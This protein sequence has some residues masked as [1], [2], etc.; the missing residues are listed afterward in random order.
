MASRQ[1][2]LQRVLKESKQFE[3]LAKVLERDAAALQDD[4]RSA[5]ASHVPSAKES[6]GI[7]KVVKQIEAATRRANRTAA[8][9]ATAAATAASPKEGGRR[10]TRRKVTRRRPSH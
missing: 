7:K 1:A 10:M 5:S 4:L 8:R 3:K 6:S 9:V 2:G